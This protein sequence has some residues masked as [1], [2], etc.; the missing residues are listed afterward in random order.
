MKKC[1]QKSLFREEAKYC[2]ECGKLIRLSQVGKEALFFQVSNLFD[3]MESATEFA[4][5]YDKY[6]DVALEWHGLERR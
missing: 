5:D 1:C 6:G 4:E 2:A 3:D